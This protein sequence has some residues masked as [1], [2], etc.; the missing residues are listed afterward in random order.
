MSHSYSHNLI[1]LVYSTKERRDLIPLEIQ[2]RLWGYIGGIGKNHGMRVLAVGG[3][4]NHVHLLFDLPATTDLAEAAKI[5]KANSSRWMREHDR[6][7]AWQ[8]GY[9]GFGVSES[10]RSL[11]ER[12]IA[13]QA[14][15]H[16]RTTYEEEFATL[17]RKHDIQFDPRWFLG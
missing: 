3:I 6:S 14:E 7:F 17:L 10:Q 2:S 15:H 1:H 4:A 8:K 5:F 11:V 13:N 9:G 12:Y 16:K